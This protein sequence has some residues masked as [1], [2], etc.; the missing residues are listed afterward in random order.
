M[1]QNLSSRTPSRAMGSSSCP[2][3]CRIM[4]MNVNSSRV[5]W[6][7]TISLRSV[8]QHCNMTT[9][10]IQL[11]FA[12]HYR[13]NINGKLFFFLY[14]QIGCKIAVSYFLILDRSCQLGAAVGWM[15]KVMLWCWGMSPG[16]GWWYWRSVQ[17]HHSP[18]S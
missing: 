10:Y 12:K 2:A 3:L 16:A 14:I 9:A 1:L 8:S 5:P 18:P 11:Q 4:P 6:E 7:E 17:A 15:P 13:G